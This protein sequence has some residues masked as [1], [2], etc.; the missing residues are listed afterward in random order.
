MKIKISII[1]LFMLSFIISCNRNSANQLNKIAG[2]NIQN[3][4]TIVQ[5]TIGGYVKKWKLDSNGCLHLRDK[6]MAEN[7]YNY[8]K[9]YRISRQVMYQYFGKPNEETKTSEHECALTYYWGSL[10]HSDTVVKVT[11]AKSKVTF[12]IQADTVYFMK[13]WFE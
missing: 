4:D 5:D 10:C 8:L 3:P 11:E 6:I 1:I 13:V 2:E 7:I 12:Y 9:K